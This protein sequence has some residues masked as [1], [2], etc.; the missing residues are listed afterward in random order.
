MAPSTFTRA[1]GTISTPLFPIHRGRVFVGTPIGVVEF[2]NGVRARSLAD[3]FFAKALAREPDDSL[4]IGTEDEGVVHVPLASTRATPLSLSS[5]TNTLAA[6]RVAKL[7]GDLYALADSALLRF[8]PSQR[9]WRSVLTASAPVLTDRNIS[10]LALSSGRLWVGYFDRGLDLLPLDLA[11]AAHQESDTLYCINRISAERSAGIAGAQT[12]VATANGLALFDQNAQL[13]Q[14]MTTKDGLLSNQVTDVAFRDSGMVIATPAGISFADR[15]GVRSL[16]AF[17]GLV[18]NHVYSVATWNRQTLAG[19]LGGLSL[20]EDDAVR[21]NYTTANSQLRH[22]W[23]T[24]L[25]RAGDDWLAGTYGAG[26]VRLDRNGEWHTFADLRAGFVVNPNAMLVE[27]GRVYAG[28]LD[29]GLFILDLA[30]GRWSNWTDGL[31][32]RNVTALASDNGFLYVGT[33]NGLVRISE[34]VLR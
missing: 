13:R 25:V 16:Y 28:S 3:G 18:N 23:I 22:N 24:A 29:R 33:D 5:D 8:D 30:S 15:S 10:A 31:P 32:S 9:T 14:M 19:T 2:R 27:N 21:V 26:V 4:A 1:N 11:Q 34:G 6:V 20:L 17:H 12:A 7:G